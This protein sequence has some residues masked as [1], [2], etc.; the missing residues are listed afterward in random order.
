LRCF[1]IFKCVEFF[2]VA[3]SPRLEPFQRLYRDTEEPTLFA[4]DQFAAGNGTTNRAL[5]HAEARRRLEGGQTS[6]GTISKGL[7]S[8]VR[9]TLLHVVDSMVASGR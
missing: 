1:R 7:P 6:F 9:R 8:L 5:V 3:K 4:G 2:T